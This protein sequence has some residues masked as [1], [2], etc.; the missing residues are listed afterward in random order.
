MILGVFPELDGIGGVQRASR[1]LAAV[2]TAYAHR[3]GGS[4]RMLALNDA[5]GKHRSQVGGCEIEYEGFDRSRWALTQAC[6][7]STDRNTRLLLAAHPNLAPLISAAKRKAPSARA[8]VVCHGIEVWAP[9]GWL[10]RV[11]LAQADCI[12]A[13]SCYTAEQVTRQQG[14][15]R[16]RVHLLPWALEPTFWEMAQQ[17]QA[18]GRPPGF[19]PGRVVLAVTRLAAV[20]AYKGVDTLIQAL[21][22]LPNDAHLVVVGEGDD[23]PR[24]EALARAQGVARRVHFLGALERDELVACYQHCDIFALPSKGEGFGLVFLEAMAFGKPVI[25]GAHGGTLDIIE[26]GTSGFLV[27]HGDVEQLAATLTHL[28]AHPALCEELG[29]HARERVAQHYLFPQFAS[30]LNAILDELLAR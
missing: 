26:H 17:A 19:P 16:K 22:R 9:L 7:R 14:V 11:A 2:L 21:V 30:R 18:P 20:D 28:L 1:H 3:V 24:L 27:P 5:L 4:V 23:R 25:G 10:R 12:L 8:V 6:W 13:P 15:Q 29:H